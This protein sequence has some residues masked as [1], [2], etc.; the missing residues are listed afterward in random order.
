MR[1][2][3]A[4][5]MEKLIP[6]FPGLELTDTENRKISRLAFFSPGAV[7]FDTDTLYIVVDPG[8]PGE[9]DTENMMKDCLFVYPDDRRDMTGISYSREIMV[10]ELV[11]KLYFWFDKFQKWEIETMLAIKDDCDL[12]EILN[13]SAEITPDT[14]WVG[15]PNLKML[16]HTF[17]TLMDDVSA[18]WRYQTRYGYIPMNIVQKLIESGELR[19]MTE[20]HRVFTNP[21][22]SFNLPYTCRNIFQNGELK[23]H[24]FIISIY[25]T[26]NRT[27]WE[28][29]DHLGDLLLPYLQKH[30]EMFAGSH[31][32]HGG[33]FQDI[34]EGKLQDVTLIKQQLSYFSWNMD[35]RFALLI[36]REQGEDGEKK[37]KN[38]SSLIASYLSRKQIPDW[39]IFSK[40]EYTLILFHEPDI[41]QLRGT[42]DPFCVQE[43]IY[44]ALSRTFCPLTELQ[45]HYQKTLQLLKIGTLFSPEKYFYCN[46]DYGLYMI[47]AKLL[48]GASVTELCHEGVIRL[49]ATD[50]QKHTEYVHTL[51]AY[52]SNDRNILKTAKALYIH[53][54]T[55][56]YRL[57]H[58]FEIIDVPSLA[59]EELHYIL[60]SIYMLK[61]GADILST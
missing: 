53:R 31:S 27:N 7:T 14:I 13:L 33:Y 15:T 20:R 34:L 23:A 37:T 30:P 22:E 41:R 48:D 12:S 61:Y 50:Q 19:M 47:V 45:Q 6:D 3:L 40:N 28:I 54:N 25:S 17:P 10:C 57:Q 5:F 35:D 26:P 49:Y 55:L 39:Q 24:I 32:F 36:V 9:C 18:I 42:L 46:A 58:I 21:R 16:G 43:T 56:S 4:L 52:L 2:S 29:A 11:N 51:Y 38:L 8:L 59:P 44:M 60:L 1:L